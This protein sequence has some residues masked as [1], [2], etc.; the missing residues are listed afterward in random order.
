MKGE[1]LFDPSNIELALMLLPTEAWDK[2]NEPQIVENED[3]TFTTGDKF[4]D[5][6]ENALAR[7]EQLED[8]LKQLTTSITT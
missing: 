5:E 6:F 3:G 4:F 1:D 2:M 7:G 8:V